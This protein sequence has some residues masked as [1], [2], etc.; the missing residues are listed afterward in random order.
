MGAVKELPPWGRATRVAV[1]GPRTGSA[2]AHFRKDSDTL[3][4]LVRGW[5]VAVGRLP[6]PL[7]DVALWR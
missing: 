1:A 2:T 5:P 6:P 7:P 3:S 4:Q